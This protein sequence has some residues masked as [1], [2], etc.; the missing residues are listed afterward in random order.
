MNTHP[1]RLTQQTECRELKPQYIVI[2]KITAVI[3]CP[4]DDINN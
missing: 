3:V 2:N 4:S 1:F